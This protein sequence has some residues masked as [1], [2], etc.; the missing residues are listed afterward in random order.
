[1]VIPLLRECGLVIPTVVERNLANQIVLPTPRG[2]Q[3]RSSS[4]NVLP[5]LLD[6]PGPSSDICSPNELEETVDP[7][8]PI[9]NAPDTELNELL[10]RHPDLPQEVRTQLVRLS[11]QS[12]NYKRL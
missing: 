7:I 3:S 8:V 9:R 5:V 12:L 10:L 1:M 6:Q 11:A 2:L 4:S